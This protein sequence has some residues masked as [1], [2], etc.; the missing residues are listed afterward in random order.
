M[1]VTVR[2]RAAGVVVLLFTA[3]AALPGVSGATSHRPG[4][5]HA[6]STDPVIVVAAGDIADCAPPNCPPARTAGRV[7]AIAPAWVLTLGDN[8]YQRGTLAEFNAEYD[9]T[10][11]RFARRTR[12]SPGNHEYLTKGADGYFDYFGKRA[13][14]KHGGYYSQRA[15][16]WQ[17]VTLNSS[18]G[19][20]TQVRCGP[21]SAQVR[22]LRRTLADSSRTCTLAYWH[23]P[24]WSSG[25]HG[26]NRA[27]RVIWRVLARNGADVVLNGH[28][29]NYERF[30]PRG[31][32]GSADARGIRQFVVGTGGGGLRAVSKPYTRLSRKRIDHRY[33][34]LRLALRPSSY[35]FRFVTA[36]GKVLDGG[37]PFGCH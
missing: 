11:G 10:W 7:R 34:V 33:G 29:H 20:C 15:G 12:P 5:D 37:G 13:H 30:A 19:D 28:D 27:V 24:P 23:H 8:Q 2:S 9:K 17:V 31:A 6:R 26:G 16:G 4:S 25:M 32:D 14:R 1:Q 21:K 3:G 18:D 22:W 36:A 35:G